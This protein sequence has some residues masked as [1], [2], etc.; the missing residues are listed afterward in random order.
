MITDN[1]VTH[2]AAENLLAASGMSLFFEFD[3]FRELGC[4]A[5]ESW[6]GQSARSSGL[7]NTHFSVGGASGARV[8]PVSA[9]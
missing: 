3:N 9:K 4:P 5:P 8:S 1:G 7:Q 6:N 2:A